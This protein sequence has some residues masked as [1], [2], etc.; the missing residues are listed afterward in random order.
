VRRR[1]RDLSLTQRR[2]TL[3]VE[4]A[5]L[6]LSGDVVNR[7][8]PAVFSGIRRGGAT[9]RREVPRDPRR[10]P[11]HPR[12]RGARPW[13]RRRSIVGWRLDTNRRIPQEV[14]RQ[15]KEG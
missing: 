4:W 10:R 13:V 12:A 2:A 9:D 8:V 1:R 11:D 14:K 7:H 3:H 15:K 6:R 5:Y